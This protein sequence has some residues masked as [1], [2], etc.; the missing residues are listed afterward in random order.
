[1]VHSP[2]TEEIEN[3]LSLCHWLVKRLECEKNDTLDRAEKNLLPLWDQNTKW[4]PSQRESTKTWTTGLTSRTLNKKQIYAHRRKDRIEMHTS[5]WEPKNLKINWTRKLYS[6]R[7]KW[8]VGS[9]CARGSI[10]PLADVTLTSFG[11]CVYKYTIKPVL[12][13]VKRK[14]L[15]CQK[16]C[17]Q[18]K[19]SNWII[20]LCP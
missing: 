12:N 14:T 2:Q 11:V 17:M 8:T 1:M 9:N 5:L 3:A 19:Y 6:R 20:C 13:G 7:H 15:F 10:S 4:T 16:K 18:M